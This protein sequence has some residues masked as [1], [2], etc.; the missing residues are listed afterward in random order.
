MNILKK[1]FAIV[2]VVF[3]ALGINAQVI[4]CPDPPPG[5]D[6]DAEYDVYPEL[7]FSNIPAVINT[8]D[9]F[10][11]DLD[12]SNFVAISALQFSISFDPNV[13]A[14]VNA[15]FS[16]TD[17]PSD[18]SFGQNV[19]EITNGNYG[20]IWTASG[21][22][23]CLE[24]GSTMISLC[25]EAVGN[26]ADFSPLIMTDNVTDI[27]A[28]VNF[29]I[30]Q[31]TCALD[32][33]LFNLSGD[34][35][36][37]ACP[38]LTINATSCATNAMDGCI[39]FSIGGG[40]PPYD[41]NTPLGFISG[42]PEG[43]DTTICGLA[44]GAISISVMDAAGTITSLPVPIQFGD[45]LTYDL[46]LIPTACDYICNGEIRI[47]NINRTD[48]TV[49]WSNFIFNVDTISGLC[50]GLYSV[51][52]TDNDGCKVIQDVTLM[53]T[54]MS[55]IV[56]IV[57]EPSC[58]GAVDGIL[59]ITPVGGTPVQPGDQYFIN[60]PLASK[61]TDNFVKSGDYP[62]EVIDAFGCRLL[63]T[64]DVN[65][66]GELD[67][68]F[69]VFQ[70]DCGEGFGQFRVSAFNTTGGPAD[71]PL[72]KMYDES[73]DLVLGG[74]QGV[75]G[76]NTYI[77]NEIPPGVY[78]L[79]L[80]EDNTGC[81]DTINFEII[82]SP[83]LIIQQNSAGPDCDGNNSFVEVIVTG[84]TPALSYEWDNGNMTNRIDN[85]VPGMYEVTITDDLNCEKIATFEITGSEP[86]IIQASN[87]SIDCDGT[88]AG[89]TLEVTIISGG[90]NLQIEWTDVDGDTVGNTAIVNNV[91]AGFYTV[92]VTD[93]DGNCSQVATATIS[94]AGTLDVQVV[95]NP[96][97]CPNGTDG[98]INL[99]V[100]GGSGMGY[101]M[102]WNHPNGIST[103][104]ILPAIP[105][106]NFD[107]ISVTDSDGCTFILPT[108]EVPCPERL[109]VEV[110]LTKEVS[111]FGAAN[112]Q[113]L[114][115]IVGGTQLYDF[116][117][118]SGETEFG[119]FGNATMLDVGTNWVIASD[120]LCAS[121]TIFFEIGTVEPISLSSTASSFTA[122][123][124]Y[125]I[126]NGEASI[127]AEGGFAPNGNY[128]FNW[129]TDGSV[130]NTNS[131]LSAGIHYIEITDES[132]PGCTI[133]D[134]VL[135]EQPDS[136]VVEIDPFTT[137]NLSCADGNSAMIGVSVTGGNAG[138]L[139]YD[140]TNSVST[141]AIADNL[142]V[143]TYC[144]TVTD[145]E[146]CSD[147]ACY[148]IV[149]PQ[150]LSFNTVPPEEPD[151]FGGSTCIEIENVSGG[152]GTNYRFSVNFGLPVPIDSC[153][154][155]VAGMYNITVFDEA[156]CSAQ[157]TMEVT[158]PAP[159]VVDLGPDIIVDLGD[160]TTV[161]NVNID[162]QEPIDSINWNPF[163]FLDCKTDNCSVVIVTPEQN[164][165]YGVTVID[166][167]GCRGFDDINV[168]IKTDRNVFISNI[169]SPNGDG[170]NDE[171]KINTG[172][173][174]K[175]I[176]SFRI[177][178]RWGNQ[179]FDA[180]TKAAGPDGS[181]A[182]DGTLK[183][184]Q[185]QPGVYVYLAKIT[186]IDDYE[187]TYK[188]SVT[189]LR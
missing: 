150:A 182:W 34:G 100:S 154:N 141:T 127:V 28:G 24:D 161:L 116:L 90:S 119:T 188:G 179:V 68:V 35:I 107:G 61:W 136:M 29:E 84:G 120:G 167:N 80:Q 187:F 57:Q 155:V 21:V 153:I 105:C 16:T 134:S 124:C 58:P 55:L 111:C 110:N 113:A 164:I 78:N 30:T 1:L 168:S 140:W 38:D 76:M 171:F 67:F 172:R 162:S 158:Q 185:L 106:G 45:P 10:C 69:E 40:V 72:F 147:S 186:F 43:H 126:A 49:E 137:L 121:D 146:G 63:D 145:T 70:H 139:D 148:D 33:I 86:L 132:N 23:T 75:L 117:W 160:T 79:V 174:V 31:P 170:Q 157:E 108:V 95:T 143:G 74:D 129:L 8:G 9:M 77:F 53:T 115:E 12:V 59:C 189:L 123:S 5:F 131:N 54:P 15:D 14:F 18:G 20:L 173:G 94:N 89:G 184:R 48:Y 73:F 83:E 135:I 165:T 46:E 103:N 26:C 163:T 101:T 44:P 96:P 87:S 151:C 152:T 112:G 180:G 104:F 169:F 2:F 32:S 109:E 102:E 4:Q 13:I 51:T 88:G 133:I 22:G 93:L 85:V 114:A 47:T 125:G 65:A 60:G 64:I 41:I 66:A 144:V 82:T 97:T 17:L 11:L 52:V 91:P 149:A 19:G 25:F 3:C 122:T 92:T 81:L 39:T 138:A 177:F 99:L 159:V 128:T 6:C 181:A 7:N 56:D 37:I 178:D 156:G 118:S 27:D 50:N 71:H 130:G 176:E 183:G 62:I 166:I 175:D 142:G 36:S 98:S 42:F